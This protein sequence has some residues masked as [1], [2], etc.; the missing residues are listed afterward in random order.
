MDLEG[1][2]EVQTGIVILPS[3]LTLTCP[4]EEQTHQRD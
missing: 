1:S 2:R 3:L 4:A